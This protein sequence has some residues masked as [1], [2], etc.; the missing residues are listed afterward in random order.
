MRGNDDVNHFR[1]RIKDTFS[2]E[3]FTLR[4]ET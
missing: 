4:P 3:S 2:E 1:D